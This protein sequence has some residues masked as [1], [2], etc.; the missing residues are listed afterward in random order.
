TTTNGSVL[1]LGNGQAVI[2]VTTVVAGTI[3]TA[4]TA[5]NL[6]T[7][8]YTINYNNTGSYTTGGELPSLTATPPAAG[9]VTLVSGATVVLGNGGTIF[10]LTVPAVANSILKLN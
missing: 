8:T 1:T 9:L 3:P 7:M 5:Y 6:G 2:L 4:M 10:S